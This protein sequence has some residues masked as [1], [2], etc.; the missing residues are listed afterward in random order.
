L[1]GFET[2][3]T[4]RFTM[5]DQRRFAA[6]SGDVNPMH[7]DAL[8]ARRTQAGVPVVHGINALLWALEQWCAIEPDAPLAEV[9]VRF[10]RF[11]AIDEEAV[12]AI[13][14]GDPAKLEL[15]V[16]GTRLMT[17]AIR[18]TAGATD[19]PVV[20]TQVASAS[21]PAVPAVLDFEQ[22]SAAAGTMTLRGAAEA[23]PLVAARIGRAAV[24]GVVGLSTLVGMVAP[25]L[26]SI[27][28]AA[29]LR[30]SGEEGA[31]ALAYRVIEAHDVFRLLGIAVAAPG[32]SGKVQA[33]VRLPPVVQPGVEALR[34]LI[35]PDALAG[36]SALVVGGSRGLGEVTA[37]LLAAGGARVAISYAVGADDAARI[38]AEIA[39]AGGDCATLRIDARAPI[40]PQL[41][42]LPF[43]PDQLYYFA[44]GKIFLQ[45]AS[46]YDPAV[47]AD[48]QR[49]Y[50]DAFAELCEALTVTGTAP[51]TAFYPSSVAV[52]ERPRGMTEYSM[53]KGAAEIL[54][55]D[56]DR[57]MPRVKTVVRRL[58]RL[59]TDQTA[60]VT[61][62]E[63]ASTEAV[64]LEAVTA[65]IA[66]GRAA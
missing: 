3:A 14:R 56:I 47:L 53:A 30:F 9:S 15:R 61:P 2:L 60:T 20:D 32:V 31:G 12:L 4:R 5:D 44:T 33:F 42:A 48:F 63:T 23:Y 38:A 65:M 39:A 43:A 26:H 49:I 18:S 7:M 24:S 29:D 11:V 66:A 46:L 50:V 62:A 27:F 16:G 13:R 22:A 8:A 34:A 64:M 19:G 25:G 45:K 17:V 28:S 1:A 21:P 54:C 55:A 58:P 51:L 52:G 35:A 10:E 37:K 59:A 57:F 40:A 6:L 41:E 36:V